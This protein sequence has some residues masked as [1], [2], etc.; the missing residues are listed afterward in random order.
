MSAL[1]AL[2]IAA[3]APAQEAFAR[4]QTLAGQW[5]G[6]YQWSGARSEG[7]KLTA[8][9]SLT[10][11]GS[12]VVEDL[13]MGP[14]EAPSM[15]SVYHLDGDALRATH[16]CAARNQPRLK[17]RTIDLEKG[18]LSF[19]FVDATNL[20]APDA[21]HVHGL[22]LQLVDAD[23]LR[24]TFLFTGKGKESREQIALRRVRG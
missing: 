4:L 15:T 7:G 16:Y 20:A 10:G 13:T 14:G 23:H 3:A 6:T 24:L 2:A 19:E 17:A 1:I 18:L 9:Y 21:P 5:E 8:R 22:E 12:A 11:A